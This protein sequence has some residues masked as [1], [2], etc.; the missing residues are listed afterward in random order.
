MY[1]CI[2][3]FSDVLN[4]IFRDKSSCQI[5]SDGVQYM[6]NIDLQSYEMKEREEILAKCM[7]FLRLLAR[8]V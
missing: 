8:Y 1:A 3:V 7:Q 5:T 2:G 6:D 4:L